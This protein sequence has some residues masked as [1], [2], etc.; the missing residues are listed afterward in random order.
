VEE[1]LDPSDVLSQP[2]HT[3]IR[4]DFMDVEFDDYSVEE[5]IPKR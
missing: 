5:P 4:T 3:G 1:P 2:G